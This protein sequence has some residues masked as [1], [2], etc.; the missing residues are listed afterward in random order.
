M[1]IED[2]LSKA[3]CEKHGE[4]TVKS[5]GRRYA[6]SNVSDLVSILIQ[7]GYKVL[8]ERPAEDYYLIQYGR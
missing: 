6:E 5:F 1:E 2:Y 3:H 4:I 7:N 8:I